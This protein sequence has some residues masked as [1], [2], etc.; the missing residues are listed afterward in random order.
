MRTYQDSREYTSNLEAL[1]QW[2]LKFLESITCSEED[3]KRY[4]EMYPDWVA[5]GERE[6]LGPRR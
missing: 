2:Q 4:R 3:A 6:K 1:R 5:I